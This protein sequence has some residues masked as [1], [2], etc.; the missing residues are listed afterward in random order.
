MAA[1]H[2]RNLEVDVTFTVLLCLSQCLVS[3]HGQID[4]KAN[5]LCRWIDGIEAEDVFAY[6]E[7]EIHR[8]G[9]LESGIGDAVDDASARRRILELCQRPKPISRVYLLARSRAWQAL[10]TDS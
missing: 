8:A 1:G 4:V 9:A 7:L 5:L 3:M 6:V 2:S 10:L